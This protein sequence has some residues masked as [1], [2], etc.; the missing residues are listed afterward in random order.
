MIRESARSCCFSRHGMD[1][2]TMR[3]SMVVTQAMVPASMAIFMGLATIM[4]T[5][6]KMQLITGY[7][8][9]KKTSG[10]CTKTEPSISTMKSPDISSIMTRTQMKCTIMMKIEMS[11][12]W[13]NRDRIHE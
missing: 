13:L 11:G 7:M 12:F 10:I 8:T 4:D 2:A 3:M 5:V 1:G 9:V 6:T